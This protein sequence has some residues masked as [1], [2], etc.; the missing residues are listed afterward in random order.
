[1][2]R[3]ATADDVPAVTALEAEVFGADAWSSTMVAE[4]LT[5]QRRS[6]WVAG[7]V[8]GYAVML[9][10]DDVVDLQRIAVAAPYRRQGVA[11]ALLET[12][13]AARGGRRM[14]LEVSALNEDA[15]A[16]YAASGFV[17]IDR[18]RRYYRDGSDAIVMEARP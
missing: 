4:E 6:A 8:Y 7:E 3:P 14:L 9:L 12:A 5:G 13:L 10:G 18:R 15:R 17:E 2:I 11:A 1:M 16:F